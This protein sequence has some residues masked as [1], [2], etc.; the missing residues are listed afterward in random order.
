MASRNLTKQ[1][2]DYR[3]NAKANRRLAGGEFSSKRVF[4]RNDL[5]GDDDN[6]NMMENADGGLKNLALPPK[7]VD[8]HD[9]VEENFKKIEA[10][11]NDLKALHK[12]RL[13]VN[14]ETD[15]AQQEHDIDIRE[16]QIK[17]IFRDTEKQIKNFLNDN[18]GDKVSPEEKKVRENM[19][20]S[21]GKKLQNLTI[22]FRTT[23]KEYFHQI[24]AQK[25]S[26]GASEIFDFL[27][28]DSNDK[29]I[30]YN[31]TGFT[32]LQLQ[33]LDDVTQMVNQRDG[34]IT[35]IAKSIEELAQIFNELA[36]LVIDQGTILDRIDFNMESAVEHAEQGV[37]ELKK[38]EDNQ[39]NALP[40]RCIV[41]LVILII[42]ML[43]VLIWK[44]S[45]SK[46]SNQNNNQK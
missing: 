21:L 29:P 27:G 22:L 45:P 23:Q 37:V 6:V 46:S 17:K 33:E 24:K 34:E 12:K 35:R 40:F 36:V 25:G 19:Q 15:E 2:N 10:K 13:L 39:K 41:V 11:I 28:N 20:R 26:G 3:N 18:K 16:Q 8:K 1:F 38:A 5:L 9:A 44:H 42:I 30:D 31:D 4:N 7:W 32:Q 14:F 43:G